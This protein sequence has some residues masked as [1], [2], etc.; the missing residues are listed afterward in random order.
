[1]GYSRVSGDVSTCRQNFTVKPMETDLDL[2][3]DNGYRAD[4]E[5]LFANLPGSGIVEL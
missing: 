3:Y 5:V 1:M 4:N 2:I